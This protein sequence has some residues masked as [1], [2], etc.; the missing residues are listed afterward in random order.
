MELLNRFGVNAEELA[1]GYRSITEGSEATVRELADKIADAVVNAL[2]SVIAFLL[3]FIAALIVLSLLSMLLGLVVKLPVL[4]QINTVLGFL[5]GIISAVAFVYVFAT[6]G[7][8]FLDKR[9]MVEIFHEIISVRRAEILASRAK[10]VIST[11]ADAVIMVADPKLLNAV[12]NGGF[13]DRFWL[14]LRAK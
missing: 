1:E 5:C 9:H 6:L 13:N 4:K 3:I 11:K 7:V 8:F 14:V 12:C 10:E 2:A